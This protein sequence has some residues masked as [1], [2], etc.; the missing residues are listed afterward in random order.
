VLGYAQERL[1]AL[2]ALDVWHTPIQMKK[3]RPGVM[4]SALAPQ[5]LEAAAVEL[6]LRETPTLGVRTRPVERYVAERESVL[7]ELE[8]GPVRVKVKSLD[9]RPV[10]AAPEFEDCRRIALETG[11]PLQEVYQQA[12]EEA[13]RRFIS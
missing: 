1:F 13:R 10:S 12:A 11:L 7:M 2:G 6:I 5:D 4:L 8:L 3:N 9:G